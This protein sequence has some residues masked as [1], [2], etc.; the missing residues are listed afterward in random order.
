MSFN[1]SLSSILCLTDLSD[2]NVQVGKTDLKLHSCIIAQSPFFRRLILSNMNSKLET[3]IVAELGIEPDSGQTE[4]V[5]VNSLQTLY[6]TFPTLTPDTVLTYLQISSYWHL[7][8]LNLHCARYM[9]LDVDDSTVIDL[10]NVA[11]MYDL[12]FYLYNRCFA[13]L[14]SRLHNLLGSITKIPQPILL[15]LLESNFLWCPDSDRS[16]LISQVQSKLPKFQIEPFLKRQICFE[17]DCD[18]NFITL[19]PIQDDGIGQLQVQ[20]QFESVVCFTFITKKLKPTSKRILIPSFNPNDMSVCMILDKPIE[21][22]S[23]DLTFCEFWLD[24][25][26]LKR[27]GTVFKDEKGLYLPVI[28][29]IGQGDEGGS[30]S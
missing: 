22:T 19:I 7:P 23:E 3:G 28:V 9:S 13:Y 25:N 1:I 16:K 15:K 14:C 5:I 17:L 24:L 26:K 6:N 4:S 27:R 18:T 12:S 10:I 21:R 11:Y 2:L 30:S 29:E 8:Q 20:I